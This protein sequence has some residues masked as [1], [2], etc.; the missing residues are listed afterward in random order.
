[1]SWG[2][3]NRSEDAKTPSGSRG[4]SQK[5]EPDC[6]P[7][8]PYRR[9]APVDLSQRRAG[10]RVVFTHHPILGN[11]VHGEPKKIIFIFE[12]SAVAFLAGLPMG[13]SWY[14]K[15]WAPV[16]PPEG[17]KS[18]ISTPHVQGMGLWAGG[19]WAW[20]GPPRTAGPGASPAMR[21]L[22]SRPACRPK[23]GEGAPAGPQ[24]RPGPRSGGTGAPGN[25][26]P[27]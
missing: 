25:C 22:A 1:M 5:P 20:C 11:T 8:Q 9:A 12:K 14:I 7:I 13:F 18:D 16:G 21:P 2:A 4:R 10:Y 23:P 15:V 17:Q 24:A 19:A 3:Q 27:R 26:P 6:C